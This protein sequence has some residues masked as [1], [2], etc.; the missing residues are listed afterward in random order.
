MNPIESWV[1]VGELRRMAD[2]LLVSSDPG[3][4]ISTA[5][6]DAVFGGSFEG[7]EAQAPSSVAAS[8]GDEAEA[9]AESARHSLA[10][11]REFAQR[12]G[13]LKN[14]A[15]THGDRLQLE[16]DMGELEARVSTAPE[17]PRRSDENLI[18]ERLMPLG[19]WLQEAVQAQSCFVLNRR[20]AVLAG[21]AENDSSKLY[22][23]ARTLAQAVYTANRHAGDVA[24]GN[25]HIKISP[26]SV[27]EVIPVNTCHGSLILGILVHR[28]LSSPQVELAARGLLQVVDARGEP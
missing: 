27:M 23:V 18:T 10:A 28:P 3:D 22:R 25:L 2:A 8:P 17:V 11:A 21:E 13:L 14:R 9:G 5:P 20:G 12:G 16:E 26:D 6:D 7:Y 15:L 4:A 19:P 1:D 24:V